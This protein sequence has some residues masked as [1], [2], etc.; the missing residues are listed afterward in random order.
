ME[1]SRGREVERAR[2]V[3][4][5]REVERPRGR[6]IDRSRVERSRELEMVEGFQ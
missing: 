5:S 1:R 3:E 4:G 6:E 2:G